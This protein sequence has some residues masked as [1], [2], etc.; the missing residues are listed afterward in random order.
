MI[1]EC[2]NCH[3]EFE[4]SDA[5]LGGNVECP[6]CG[7]GY[8]KLKGFEEDEP[9]PVAVPPPVEVSASPHVDAAPVASAVAKQTF[10]TYARAVW[11]FVR[12]QQGPLIVAGALLVSALLIVFGRREHATEVVTPP[13]PEEEPHVVEPVVRPQP[14]P[15]T[16][17]PPRVTE[18]PV[19]TVKVPAPPP[20]K[21]EEPKPMPQVV[22]SK[23]VEK[24]KPETV[25]PKKDT[26]QPSPPPVVVSPKQ[27][28]TK[29]Q[30]KPALVLVKNAAKTCGL[31]FVGQ[32]K[33]QTY[34]YVHESSVGTAVNLVLCFSTKQTL[35]LKDPDVVH[36]AEAKGYLRIQMSKNLPGVD[37]TPAYLPCELPTVRG[38]TLKVQP[39]EV[40]GLSWQALDWEAYTT[41]CQQLA[42]HETFADWVL[43]EALDPD[44]VLR[45]SDLKAFD[46][47]HLSPR[48]K[49]MRDSFMLYEKDYAFVAGKL[50]SIRRYKSNEDEIKELEAAFADVARLRR[51][52]RLLALEVV[53]D[54]M[55][56]KK[57]TLPSQGLKARAEALLAF[58]NEA[59]K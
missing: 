37:L 36:L 52:T 53:R 10:Q 45:R 56:A 46:S 17:P 27:T 34:L 12:K 25:V 23:P 49:S 3:E 32:D 29:E 24:P 43:K 18:T 50:K 38:Q 51:E 14:P 44:E 42:A 2:E 48:V 13:P 9:K 5:D 8:F 54:E 31:G 16:P 11:D 15:P 21:V 26:P 57:S 33:N 6:R 39:A 59:L 58:L 40:A 4:M 28:L 55:N 30:L 22:P 41:L 7:S 47:P 19:P 35:R 20:Q 1:I